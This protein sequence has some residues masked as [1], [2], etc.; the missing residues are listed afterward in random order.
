VLVLGGVAAFGAALPMAS[1]GW[2]TALQRRT[3]AAL[4]GRAYSAADTA[5]TVP[6]TFSIAVG[7]A[8]VAVV[9]YR[10]LLAVMALVC[11]ASAATLLVRGRR[12]RDVLDEEQP[13]LAGDAL[14]LRGA[15]VLERD[16]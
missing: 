6:Q 10:L 7:A 8:L 3:P 4:Q 5:L 16:A 14:E 11:A 2:L 13:Q 9:D 12:L 15:P 1:V